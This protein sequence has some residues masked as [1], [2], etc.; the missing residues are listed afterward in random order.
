MLLDMNPG[1]LDVRGL[2]VGTPII[3]PDLPEAKPTAE[4]WGM[5]VAA[6]QMVDDIRKTLGGVREALDV[7]IANEKEDAQTSFNVLTKEFKKLIREDES[8]KEPSLKAASMAKDRLEKA[9]SL[10]AVHTRALRQLEKDL[11][12]FVKGIT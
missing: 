2:P 3:V 9:E 8:L 7:S 5:E 11:E 6:R 1:L 10:E 12:E 4:A